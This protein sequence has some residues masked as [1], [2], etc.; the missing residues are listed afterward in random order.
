MKRSPAQKSV[1]KIAILSQ[2]HNK[3]FGAYISLVRSLRVESAE[4]RCNPA[5]CAE[6]RR[7]A[8]KRHWL[9][10]SGYILRIWPLLAVP[11][12]RR[13]SRIAVVWWAGGVTQI[14]GVK[15]LI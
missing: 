9:Y 12:S 15:D 13:F 5:G 14:G 11:I 1:T 10:R 6:L 3:I 8:Q 4:L 2:L 7:A